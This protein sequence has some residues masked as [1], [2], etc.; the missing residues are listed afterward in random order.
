MKTAEE[1]Y[2]ELNVIA[3]TLFERVVNKVN[4]L[5]TRSME[6]DCPYIRQCIIEMVISKLGKVV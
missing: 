2:P 1:Q 5:N 6:S 4:A 3:T